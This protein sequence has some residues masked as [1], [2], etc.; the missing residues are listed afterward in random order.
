MQPEAE[1]SSSTLLSLII[2]CTVLIKVQTELKA[3]SEFLFAGSVYLFQ[4]K[5]IMKATL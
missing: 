2:S 3:E 4:F 5:L 1:K